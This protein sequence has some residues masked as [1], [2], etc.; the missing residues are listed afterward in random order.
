MP[1]R[2]RRTRLGLVRLPRSGTSASGSRYLT[3]SYPTIQVSP[4]RMTSRA[5]V[6]P[7]WIMLALIGG[8]DET[9]EG[10]GDPSIPRVDTGSAAEPDAE[11]G[12]AA[13]SSISLPPESFSELPVG[14]L[15]ALNARG[16]RIPQIP[17]VGGRPHNVVRGSFRDRSRS[18]WA[19]LCSA[20]GRS[21]I[22]VF[23][24]G[25]P[26]YPAELASEDNQAFMQLDAAG[27]WEYSRLLRA[28]PAEQIS[29]YADRHGTNLGILEHDGIE[30]AFVGKASVIYYFERGTW[31]RIDGAD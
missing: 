4:P 27:R 18:D 26:D 8:C 7:V 1:S 2:G 11:A 19:V 3:F 14:V 31:L 22:L 15:L 20:Q 25:S 30:D 23:W 17:N 13:D 21:A 12:V 28:L 24:S 9:R 16:C 29:T 10:Q 6:I 5:R